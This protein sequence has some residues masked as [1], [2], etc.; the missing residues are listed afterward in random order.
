MRSEALS[1]LRAAHH[2]QML[3]KKQQKRKKFSKRKQYIIASIM[4]ALY[5]HFATYQ[6][7]QE[8][9]LEYLHFPWSLH[10]LNSYIP[11][12]DMS[13]K[14]LQQCIKQLSTYRRKYNNITV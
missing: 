1:Y 14:T 4:I 10:T 9:R 5:T 11:G 7:D 6:R 3:S 12:V 2:F 8:R 13:E